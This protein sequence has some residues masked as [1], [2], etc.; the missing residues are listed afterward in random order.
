[1]DKEI[2]VL[3]E[4]MNEIK[5]SLDNMTQKLDEVANELVDKSEDE[6]KEKKDL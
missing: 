1:E 6:E 2:A 5:Q 4:K 3:M